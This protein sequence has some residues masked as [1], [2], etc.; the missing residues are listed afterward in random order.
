MSVQAPKAKAFVKCRVSFRCFSETAKSVFGSLASSN[1]H[2]SV[3][4][5]FKEHEKNL[6]QCTK[7]IFPNHE[8]TRRLAGPIVVLQRTKKF[9]AIP[10]S[11]EKF[12]TAD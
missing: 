3:A 8:V 4:H 2:A 5:G 10:S 9:P 6:R 1:R 12:L 11:F 7:N